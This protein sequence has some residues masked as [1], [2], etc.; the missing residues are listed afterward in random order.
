MMDKHTFVADENGIS[1][2]Y[3]SGLTVLVRFAVRNE[4]SNAPS[5]HIL[6]VVPRHE[7]AEQ[8][9]FDFRGTQPLNFTPD[10]VPYVS[11]EFG[12]GVPP[13]RPASAGDGDPDGSYFRD[14][15]RFGR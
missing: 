9:V 2:L 15:H 7:G 4:L 5:W 8:S 12:E 10:N 11:V 3:E 6:V 13:E 1:L 14:L